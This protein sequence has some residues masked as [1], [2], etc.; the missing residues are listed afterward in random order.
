MENNN[1]KD[2][3]L[4]LLQ[5][6]DK[7]CDDT[8]QCK[9][10]SGYGKGNE[11]VNHMLADF[12]LANGVIVSPFPIGT[13]YYRIVTKRGKV[14]NPYFKM[15]R[16]AELNWYNVENVLHDLGK[17]V[18]LTREEAEK[19]LEVDGVMEATYTV[20]TKNGKLYKWSFTESKNEDD[21]G[22]GIY[23]AVKS[24]SGDVFSYD[25]R[26][27]RGYKFHKAC[28][29]YLLAYYGENLDELS[30]DD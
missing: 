16:K 20:T 26:Y 3:L 10:C 12:L 27:M 22:N 28:V 1:M 17:T 9:D 18:F 7:M 25:C 23:I 6:A 30:E 4:K 13:T 5:T 11:C 29:D 19:A 24:P 14:G 21:Y 8:K 2:R 15:I